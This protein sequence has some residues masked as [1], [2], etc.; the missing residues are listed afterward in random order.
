M[1][2]VF[3]ALCSPAERRGLGWKWGQ[4]EAIWGRG[5]RTVVFGARVLTSGTRKGVGNPAWANGGHFTAPH[6]PLSVIV[7]SDGL[8]VP[9]LQCLC[10]YLCLDYKVRC[11]CQYHRWGKRRGFL[12]RQALSWLDSSFLL[13]S[14][15]GPCP[16]SSR[17]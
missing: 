6:V 5:R 14:R 9:C 2:E 12:D 3:W 8:S 1:G 10:R 7:E 11:T 17:S 15:P 4:G 13:R 16:L